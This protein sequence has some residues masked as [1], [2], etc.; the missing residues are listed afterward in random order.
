MIGQSPASSRETRKRRREKEGRK[1][2]NQ[3]AFSLF[4]PKAKKEKK[5]GNR[6]GK[7][8]ELER[9]TVSLLFFFLAEGTPNPF[10]LSG[11]PPPPFSGIL[12]RA[13]CTSEEQ[14]FLAGKK[15]GGGGKELLLKREQLAMSYPTI[16]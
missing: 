5:G 14:V 6:N 1:E 8:V 2:G 15:A 13:T 3:V 11:P 7:S 12:H 4:P 16:E 9:E 10:C